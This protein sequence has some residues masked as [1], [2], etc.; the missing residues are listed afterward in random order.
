[1]LHFKHLRQINY[2]WAVSVLRYSDGVHP[3]NLENDL[4]NVALELNPA[5]AASASKVYW[6]ATGWVSS[7]LT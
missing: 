2:K 3:S 6:P 1:M 5:W 7:S 4:E